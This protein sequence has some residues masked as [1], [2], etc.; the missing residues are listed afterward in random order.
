MEDTAPSRSHEDYTVGWISALP[1]E[2]ATAKAMLDDRHDKLSK[3]PSDHNTYTLG[4]IGDHNVVIASLPAGVTGKGAAATVAANML[5]TFT[6]IRFGLMVG[7]GGGVP[8]KENDIRLGDVVVSKPTITSGGVVQYDFGK[9]IQEGRFT[10]TGALNKPPTVLLTAVADLQATHMGGKCK[11][12]EF[13]PD[14]G[15]KFNRPRTH[16]DL[17][18]SSYGHQGE[19][20]DKCLRCDKSQLIQRS[21]RSSDEPRIHYGVIASGDQV[22]K[23]GVT[24]DRISRELDV[25]CFE[26]EAA[27]LADNF[28]CLVVRGIS[29]YADSHKNKGWQGYAAAV[30]AAYAKELLY[31]ISPT[32]VS[33]TT[34]AARATDEA[35]SAQPSRSAASQ[36]VNNLSGKFDT[37][38]GKGYFGINSA[39]DISIN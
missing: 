6:S 31:I 11:L 1:L 16:D 2:K 28:P 23:D 9:T 27:G 32:K 19:P 15:S 22:M 17:F 37:G 12:V 20:S 10:R 35:T 14:I 36:Q 30:A 38:G 5:S 18:E 7:I 8:S 33:E 29:D 21:T 26:M 13:L 3:P 4:R 25:L 39:G 24:R 34:S